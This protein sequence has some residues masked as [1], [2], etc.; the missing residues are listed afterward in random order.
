MNNAARH[1]PY[2][3]KTT[4]QV[5]HQHEEEPDELMLLA[6]E[7]YCHAEHFDRLTMRQYCE[8]FEILSPQIKATTLQ[9]VARSLAACPFAPRAVVMALALEP[10]SISRAILVQSPVLGQLDMLR[11]I[12]MGTERHAVMVA[13]R[14]DIGPSVIKRL[15]ELKADSIETALD[16]NPALADVVD[17]NQ[18][19]EIFTKID[20][21][22]QPE[23]IEQLESIE[24]AAE[25]IDEA[26]DEIEMSEGVLSAAE[27]EQQIVNELETVPAAEV[28]TDLLR[29]AARGGR[30]GESKLV[31]NKNPV[32]GHAERNH[33]VSTPAVAGVSMETVPNLANSLE[34][35]AAAKSRQGMATLMAKASGFSLETAFQVLEDTSGDTLAVFMKTHDIDPAA[36]SRILMLTFPS[37]GLSTQN[38]MRAVRFYKTLEVESCREA[39]DQWPK[40]E[41]RMEEPQKVKHQP[42]LDDSEGVRWAAHENDHQRR[43]V[44]LEE[45]RR[46]AL[47]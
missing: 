47:G 19:A 36:A 26:R 43:D 40:D 9:L 35:I 21:D 17:H 28:A 31:E 44:E 30:L 7:R 12:D 16:E 45:A 5:R 25:L 6:T 33:P 14:H 39:V 29:A 41:P 46:R 27:F 8:A 13:E 34:L 11:I 2:A 20:T 1:A 38:A 15:H 42:Y 37:V 10:V 3:H 23:Q 32:A 18:S 24:T 4:K 22:V